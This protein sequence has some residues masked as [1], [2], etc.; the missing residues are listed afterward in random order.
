MGLGLITVASLVAAARGELAR[1]NHPGGGAR[2]E[3][4]LPAQGEAGESDAAA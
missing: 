1:S 4:V 2:V 3:V